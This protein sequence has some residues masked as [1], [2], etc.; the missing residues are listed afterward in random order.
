MRRHE[1][2]AIIVTGAAS[3]IGKACA[4]RLAA[5]GGKVTVS[6]INAEGVNATVAEIQAA[7][8]T[9]TGFA[10]DVSDYDACGKLVAHCVAEFGDVNC[11]VNVA[12]IGGFVR[13]EEETR[14]HF[15][16]VLDVN[17]GGTFNTI[18]HALPHLMKNEGNVVNIASIAGLRAHPYAAAYCASKGGVIMMTKAL[19]M[20]YGPNNIRFNAVCPGGIKTPL[21]KGFQPFEGANMQLIMRLMSVNGQF[22]KPE[23]IASSVA[24]VASDEA[25]FMTGSVLLNDGGST[26]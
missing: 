12:G 2:R 21:L 23:T 19:A 4:I 10:C 26:L 9:A 24:Y 1:D 3:G 5:E 18:H 16:Q 7:G 22:G 11:V 14:A 17:L 6:D 15:S 25:S 20:E 13:T 8:G